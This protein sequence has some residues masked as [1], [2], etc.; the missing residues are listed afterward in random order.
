MAADLLDKLNEDLV[1]LGKVIELLQDN[2][3]GVSGRR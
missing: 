1:D 2:F 3:A